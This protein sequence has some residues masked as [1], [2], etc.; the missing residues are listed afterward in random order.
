MFICVALVIYIIITEYQKLHRINQELRAMIV[1]REIMYYY[2]AT[3]AEYSC[4]SWDEL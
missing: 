1:L 3:L 2:T 4:N